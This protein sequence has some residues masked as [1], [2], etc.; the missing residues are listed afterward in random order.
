MTNN[1]WSLVPKPAGANVVSGKWIFRHKLHSDGSLARYKAR[2]VVRGCSQ[3]EGIDYGE[4]FSPVIKPGTIRSVLSIATSFSWPIHQL[5]VK[6]VFLQVRYLKQFILNNP[7][8]L[9]ILLYLI[10]F[11]NFISLFMALNKLLAHG[12]C[13]LRHFFPRLV[14]NN[15]NVILPFLFL[16]HPLPLHIF[17]FM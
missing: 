14:L 10:I 2:W 5:D 9:L 4:T 11:A 17:F 7:L 12:S 6:N 8:A 1:T 16:K 15:L 13:D 3:Q